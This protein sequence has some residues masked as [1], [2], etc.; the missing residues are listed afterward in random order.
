[1]R[2]L[3]RT[4]LASL[5]PHPRRLSTGLVAAAVAAAVLAAPATA[6]VAAAPSPSAHQVHARHPS[7]ST[8]AGSPN[9]VIAWNAHAGAA[10]VAACFIGGNGPQEARMY[11]MMHIAIHDALNAIDRHRGRTPPTC[12]PHEGRPRTRPWRR[13]H[14]TCS[15][16]PSAPSPSSSPPTA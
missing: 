10:S 1:M 9:A 11:A 12:T 7:P 3:S 14:V 13:P 6:S 5:T 2:P 16:P 8:P 15:S 4:W